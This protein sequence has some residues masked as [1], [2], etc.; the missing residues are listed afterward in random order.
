MGSSVSSLNKNNTEVP[1]VTLVSGAIVR[2][3]C[4]VLGKVI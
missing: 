4:G 2:S 3:I 1:P